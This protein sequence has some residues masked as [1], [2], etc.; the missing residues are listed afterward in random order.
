MSTFLGVDAA[1]RS[2]AANRPRGIAVL[3]DQGLL[4]WADIDRRAE[5]LANGFRRAGVKPGDY[6]AWLGRNRIEFPIFVVAARRARAVVVGLN[7]R[8]LPAELAAI[9]ADCTP[10]LILVEPDLAPLIAART[11][12]GSGTKLVFL[13]NAGEHASFA[14]LLAS[15]RDP[16]PAL[17]PDPLDPVF[18]YYTSGTTGKPKGVLHGLARTDAAVTAETPFGWGSDSTTLIVAPVFHLTGSVWS[19]SSLVIGAQQVI[20]ASSSA[21]LILAAID[22]WRV[23]HAILVPTMIRLVLNEMRTSDVHIDSLEIVTYGGAPM[24]HS[25][26]REA[27]AGLKCRFSQGY[28]LTETNCPATFLNPDDHVLEGPRA[29]LLGSVGRGYAGIKI[30]VADPATGKILGPGQ[31]G[32]IQI[33]TPWRMLGY[34]NDT[35]LTATVLDAEGWFRTGD[36]GHLDED[37]YL[38]LSDRIN[39]MIVTGG[40]NVMPSEVETVL[41]SHAAVAEAAVFGVDDPVWGETVIAAVVN[42]TGHQISK[43]ELIQFSRARLAHYKC[44]KEIVVVDELPHSATGKVLRRELRV[45][46]QRREQTNA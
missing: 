41:V 34:R 33:H 32:E 31:V 5:W 45:R 10:K 35:A 6:V 15:G 42:R 37:G 19:Q 11:G 26:L 7:W 16:L 8:L 46:F 12:E 36:G 3:S 29:R 18:L 40:E 39:D 27:I 43:D 28:G 25:L 23:T 24:T 20:S 14:Q 2:H 30:R 17:T 13:D 22:R 4:T 38:F 44:P 21:A 9:I 1:V